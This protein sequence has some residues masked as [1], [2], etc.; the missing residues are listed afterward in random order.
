M[1]SVEPIPAFDDNYIWCLHKQQHCLLVDPGDG[2]AAKAYLDANNLQLEAIL[3]TH[4]HPDHTGGIQQLQQDNV[5][6]YAPQSAHIPL[7]DIRV[8]DGEFIHA[9]GLQFEVIGTP[10]HTLDHVIYHQAEQACL[11]VGDTLFMA[12]CGRLFEGNAEQMLA[13]MDKISHL[14]NHTNIYPAHEYS[15]SNLDFALHIDPNNPALLLKKSEVQALRQQGKPSLPV[16]LE[17]ELR[18][19][20]FLR[21]REH[22]IIQAAE[23][24]QSSSGILPPITDTASVFAAIRAQKDQF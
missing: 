18:Y 17:Q 19:N 13:A 6:V 9:L 15:L 22:A 8:Q 14:A 12:G 3:I 10:G 7:A 24:F 4:W 5:R 16:Q 2:N 11:F 23:A 21:C 20:P 1:Y